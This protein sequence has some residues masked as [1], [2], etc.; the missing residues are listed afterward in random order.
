[1]THL[2]YG[3]ILYALLAL[4]GAHAENLGR[5]FFTPAQREQMDSQQIKQYNAVQPHLTVNGIVQKHGGLRTVWLNGVAQSSVPALGNPA[6]VT[7]TLP[8]QSQALTIKVGE[9]IQIAPDAK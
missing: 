6:S 9:K 2:I 3:A 4:S 5:L 1:M 7:L 8:H